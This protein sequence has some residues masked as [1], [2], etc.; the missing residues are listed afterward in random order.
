VTSLTNSKATLNLSLTASAGAAPSAFTNTSSSARCQSVAYTVSWTAASG[1]HRIAAYLVQ[2]G[3][4]ILTHVP[5]TSLHTTLPSSDVGDY[6]KA[7]VKVWAVDTTGRRRASASVTVT[8]QAPPI[9]VTVNGTTLVS[10][11]DWGGNVSAVIQG[12]A[13]VTL[14]MAPVC[15]AAVTAYTISY[16]PPSGVPDWVD[17]TIPA[18]SPTWNLPAPLVDSIAAGNPMTLSLGTLGY[19]TVNDLYLS[20]S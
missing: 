18:S 1:P 17:L 4:E 6:G 3:G 16:S 11:V 15:R 12:G 7:T 19:E 8:P 13:T 5:G 14:S 10:P 20:N 2:V 9:T